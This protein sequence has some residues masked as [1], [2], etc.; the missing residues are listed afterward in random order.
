M[1]TYAVIKP[2]G[3][4]SQFTPE[5]GHPGLSE[6]GDFPKNVY[7]IGRL[8]RDSEGLLLLTDDNNLKR[9][10]LEGH[11]G[12][13]VW[14]TYHVQVEGTPTEE[15]I[16]AL[17]RPMQLKAKGKAFTEEEDRFIVCMT[18]QLGYGRWEELKYEVRRSW[19][20]RFDW[21]IKSRTPKELENRFKQLVCILASV[22]FLSLCCF[23]LRFVSFPLRFISP[24]L[25][26]GMTR[27]EC[28]WRVCV[29][30]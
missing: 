23:S 20:F 8:D 3:M 15:N 28:L 30:E 2:Y 1:A 29:P 25:C 7:P 26:V 22:W 14:K 17:E 16:L 21:F 9:R 6:L 13:K 11:G 27:L 18:H 19:N 24:S 5:A 12:R 4:L 10:I